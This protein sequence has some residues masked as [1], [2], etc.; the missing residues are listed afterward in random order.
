MRIKM[1][2]CRDD[3]RVLDKSF[4]DTEFFDATPFEPFTI[5]SPSL[6]LEYKPELTGYNYFFIEDF[7]RWYRVT[8]CTLQTGNRVIISGEVDVLAS[9]NSQIKGLQVNVDKYQSEVE[10]FIPDTEFGITNAARTTVYESD[11]PLIHKES[12]NEAAPDESLTGYLVLG[13]IGVSS[14]A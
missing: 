10:Q 13:A 2:T 4:L 14:P 12:F 6:I 7:N 9:F 5:T 11:S 3:V 8:N 1:A